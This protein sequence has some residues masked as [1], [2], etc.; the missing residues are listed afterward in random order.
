MTRTIASS[1]AAAPLNARRM[2]GWLQ[3]ILIVTFCVALS[4]LL[5]AA[6][7]WPRDWVVPLRSWI[8]DL[9]RWLARDLSLGGLTLRDIT[10]GLAA[11]MS[12]P[13]G[14]LEGLLY[15]GFENVPFL[16]LPWVLIVGG[17]VILGHKLQGWGLGLFAGFCMAYL[18][19]FGLW[20]DS[21]RTLSLVLVT[22]PLAAS[23]GLALGI[24]MFNNRR[25]E[26]WG[27]GVLDLMQATPHL[28]YLAPIVVF[29]GFGA[30]PAMLASAAFALPP[31][32]RCVLLGMR[33]VPVASIEAATMAGC[34]P[35]QILWRARLP[36]ALAELLVGV[37]QV[38][39]QTLAMTVIASLVGATG[40]GHR[41]LVALQQLQ[42]GKALE[43]G[44]AIVLIAIVLDRLTRAWARK[45]ADYQRKP[46]ALL[47]RHRHLLTFAAL[48]VVAVLFS[49]YMPALQVLPRELTITTA[50]AWDAAVRWISLTFAGPLSAFRDFVT[51]FVLIPIRGVFAW[52]PWP[53]V[54][55][56]VGWTSWRLAGVRFALGNAA[57]VLLVAVTGFWAP[58]MMT[59][60]LSTLAVIICMAIGVPLGIA[61]A[62]RPSFA[63]VLMTACDTLQTFP[64]FIYLIP[65]I[66]LFRVGDLACLFA[67]IGFAA[68]PAIR[69]TYLGVT[70]VSETVME[71]AIA[72]GTTPRQRL[73]HVELPLALPAILL[74][75][76]QTI[77]MALSMTAITA[78]IGSRDLGQ[79]ILKALP[80]VDTGR[81]IL[82]GLGIAI[83]GI[84][85]NRMIGVVAT[86]LKLKLGT[87]Q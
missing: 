33:G 1:P 4:L 45:A 71:A 70:G 17:T 35:G 41:L 52:L 12:L 34:R 42:V 25:V 16:P 47:E 68:V 9:L 78:L 6:A 79:E 80:E 38:V 48:A 65:V 87:A 58:A 60:Y 62:H 86:N 43:S 14:F 40:L 53:L 10:R 81:G 36:G 69:F 32:T 84:V 50:P 39:M 66:M 27:S 21:M 55:A 75:L 15:K 13:L 7:E 44:V 31:M 20:V 28:A 76:N 57:M 22:V 46:D 73:W 67:I 29:F 54:V 18:A 82:A 30:V 37:N 85:A 26:A 63:R 5:P 3:L 64:S 11:L 51:V 59:L 19:V 72:N 83:I 77:L 8:T 49:L 2:P 23:L 24:W 74:G 61:A 56:V